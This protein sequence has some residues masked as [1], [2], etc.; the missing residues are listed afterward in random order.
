MGTDIQEP[1]LRPP[2][3]HSLQHIE[4]KIKTSLFTTEG[5]KHHYEIPSS[6]LSVVNVN[7]LYHQII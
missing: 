7:Y 3:Y 4:T 6:L 5:I 2:T 1:A